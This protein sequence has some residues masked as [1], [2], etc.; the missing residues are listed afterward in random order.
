MSVAKA[1]NR[2]GRAA[3]RGFNLVEMVVTMM[4]I[5][6]AAAIAYPSFRDMTRNMTVTESTNDLVAAIN[7][8]RTEATKRGGFVA[9]IGSNGDDNWT[10]GWRVQADG[11]RDTTFGTDEA[12][13]PVLRRA[14]AMQQGYTMKTKANTGTSA[15]IV[16][17]ASGALAGGVASFDIN[18]CRPDGNAAMSRRITVSGSGIVSS[19]RN[20][21]GSPAPAC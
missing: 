3:S 13:D 12:V 5:S 21:T 6:V 2:R 20:T 18:I 8:A 11:N 10:S 4:V 15:R 9:V 17:N 19:R 16:F 14:G 7:L 1:T